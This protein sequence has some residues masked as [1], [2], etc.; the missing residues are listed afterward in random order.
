MGIRINNNRINN[1]RIVEFKIA[2]FKNYKLELSNCGNE[3]DNIHPALNTVKTLLK[4]H[5]E[6]EESAA[7]PLKSR[8]IP[9][10]EVVVMTNVPMFPSE[11]IGKDDD[12]EED[13][14]MVKELA[15]N[16]YNWENPYGPVYE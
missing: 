3:F 2:Q 7:L 12:E 9:F 13:A 14:E 6:T 11:S 5:K 8:K 16:Y 15:R 4:G 1:N 10:D